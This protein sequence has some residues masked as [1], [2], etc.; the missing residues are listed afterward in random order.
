MS[1]IRANGNSIPTDVSRPRIGTALGT[2]C[3]WATDTGSRSDSL[4][5]TSQ[6]SINIYRCSQRVLG[7]GF[8]GS[9]GE[10]KRRGGGKRNQE[11]GRADHSRL[12][13]VPGFVLNNAEIWTK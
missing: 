11:K 5:V 1:L 13:R 8:H 3:P 2:L 12:H 6:P 9:H 4:S 7:P 10:G